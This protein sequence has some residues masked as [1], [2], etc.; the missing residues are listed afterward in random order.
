MSNTTLSEADQTTLN[1]I[2]YIIRK[3]KGERP[4]S[5]AGTHKLTPSEGSNITSGMVELMDYGLRIAVYIDPSR[6]APVSDN[7]F[8]DELPEEYEA[9]FDAIVQN[10]AIGIESNDWEEYYGEIKRESEAIREGI[11]KKNEEVILEVLAT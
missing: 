11:M 6:V 7:G 3:L 2:N 4:E 9:Y 8:D 5:E 1:Q 10:I